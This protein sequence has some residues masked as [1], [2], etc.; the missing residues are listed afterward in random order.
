MLKA[1]CIAESNLDPLAVSPVGAMGLCQNMPATWKESEQALNI[2]GDPF[3][4]SI[5]IQL[6]AYYMMKQRRFWTS[7]RPDSDRMSLAMASYNAGAGH[8][9]KAQKACGGGNM[10]SEIIKC[11]PDI[12]G[13][14]S[15]ETINYVKR[16]WNF[17]I[18]MVLGL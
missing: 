8:L 12:T 9:Y 16:I 14:H 17:Y 2:T 6:S 3:Q 11:L 1:Q 4:A 13:R 18:A 5:N 15:E 7:P 10:Y